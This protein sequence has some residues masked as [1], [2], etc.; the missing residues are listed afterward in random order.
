MI[1]VVKVVRSF[2][3]LIGASAVLLPS[4]L[5]NVRATQSFE[6]PI[7]RLRVILR[8]EIWHRVN[9]LRQIGWYFV[10]DN[11]WLILMNDNCFDFNS[12]EIFPKG[13]INKK[14]HW[15]YFGL[16]P[17][18]RQTIIWT[19][20]GLVQWL[21]YKK[22]GLNELIA[23]VMWKINDKNNNV[24]LQATIWTNA[25][26]L[27]TEPLGIKPHGFSF[28]KKNLKISIWWRH[29]RPQHGTHVRY[30]KM[31]FHW[32]YILWYLISIGLDDG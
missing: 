21:K 10:G 16:A 18:M 27:L 12:I 14:R 11:F 1:Y 30:A 24:R 8:Y 29:S 23:M 17:N 13:P 5:S 3:N 28:K 7:S 31:S 19:N 9:T 25:G 20:N 15:L 2:W 22:L 26:L 4:C 6:H 32:K